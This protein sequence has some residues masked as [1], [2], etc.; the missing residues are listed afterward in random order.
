MKK[1]IFKEIV[2]PE[3]VH[4]KVDGN[5]LKISGKDG[6]ITRKMNLNKLEFKI[7][8]GKIVIGRKKATKNEKKIINTTAAH[9]KNMI[10]G[11]QKK[12]E[13][14]LK[15]CF[16][17]FPFTVEAKGNEILIKNFLGEK[18][19]RKVDVQKDVEIKIDK[20]NITI[21]SADKELAGQAAANL[22]EAT[23]V[24][25]RDRRVFQDGIYITSKAGRE[26]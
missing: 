11:V 1:E 12:F 5:V 21:K 2:I 13:Y 25:N 15:V 18:V 17:H 4:A 24:K 7:S 6:E 22:E 20:Q 23:K 16:S 3:G 19:P 14:Q 8:E 26:I 9:I 10:I